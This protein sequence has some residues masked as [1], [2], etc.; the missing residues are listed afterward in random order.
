VTGGTNFG[1]MKHVGEAVRNH[2]LKHGNKKPI[3]AIG[4][5]HWGYISNRQQLVNSQVCISAG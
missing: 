4:I 3:I 2:T 1:V 5:A